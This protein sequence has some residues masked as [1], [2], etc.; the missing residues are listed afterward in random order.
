M[1][2]AMPHDHPHHK[3]LMYALRTPHVNFWEERS[4]LP[5]EV[6]GRQIHQQ[7]D[8]LTEVGE[9]V[10]FVELLRWETEAVEAL[11]ASGARSRSAWEM[12]AGA[13][14]GRGT[15]SSSRWWTFI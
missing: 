9:H 12:T 4:T 7:F 1:S 3:G 11:F 8:E 15:R 2:L 14:C 10:G 6:V 5:G 13:M